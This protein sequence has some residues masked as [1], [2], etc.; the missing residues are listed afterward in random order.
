MRLAVRETGSILVQA[1]RERVF[2]VLRRELA[3]APDL[4]ATPSERLEARRA[5]EAST[6]VLRDAPGGTRLFHARTREHP[7][8]PRQSSRD[9]LR[10]AVEAELLRVQ[11]LAEES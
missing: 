9:K 8:L 5:G 2:E 4:R 10:A 11:R 1:P 3:H 6:F 7:I